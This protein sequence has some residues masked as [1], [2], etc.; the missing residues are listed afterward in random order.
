MLTI[1][2]LYS[3]KIRVDIVKNPD[4]VN[5]GLLTKIF[6]IS[7]FHC[8]MYCNVDFYTMESQEQIDC[9]T[10]WWKSKVPP[11]SFGSKQKRG[12]CH[13]PEYFPI[14]MT[15]KCKWKESPIFVLL[16]FCLYLNS[17]SKLFQRVF[18]QDCNVWMCGVLYLMMSESFF[19]HFP[20]FSL[21]FC[22]GCQHTTINRSLHNPKQG[23][24]KMKVFQA[25]IFLNVHSAFFFFFLKMC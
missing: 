6:T 9:N 4:L 16:F 15:E 21:S 22:N 13:L 3:S 12:K 14:P 20:F 19:N 23:E 5:S 24:K 2:L 11:V 17:N 25:T 1:L 18:H 8:T 7:G 10:S